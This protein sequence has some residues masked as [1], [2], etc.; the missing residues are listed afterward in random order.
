MYGLFK[1][2]FFFQNNWTKAPLTGLECNV[3]RR[4][5]RETHFYLPLY[6][7]ISNEQENRGFKILYNNYSHKHQLTKLCVDDINLLQPMP[8]KDLS[9]PVKGWPSSPPDFWFYPPALWLSPQ[10]PSA[11]LPS[12]WRSPP[13]GQPSA[14]AS[15]AGA[16]AGN[17]MMVVREMVITYH[18][19]WD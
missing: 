5:R 2:F 9:S 12:P 17:M 19:T 14:G 15:P 3:T 11:P 13:D 10:P 8:R 18:L 4:V 1:D 6:E 7:T 16:E